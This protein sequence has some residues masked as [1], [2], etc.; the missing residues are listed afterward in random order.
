MERD[1]PATVSSGWP[2]SHMQGHLQQLRKVSWNI[3]LS[4]SHPPV[5]KTHVVHEEVGKGKINKLYPRPL[6]YSVKVKSGEQCFLS[7]QARSEAVSRERNSVYSRMGKRAGDRVL[8]R[9]FVSACVTAMKSHFIPQQW[10]VY[11]VNSYMQPGT[12]QK[13][14]Q[15]RGGKSRCNPCSHT[16][17]VCSHAHDHHQA[18]VFPA[19]CSQNSCS[20]S[21]AASEGC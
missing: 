20:S 8:G 18:T 6:S 16:V 5:I 21:P 15:D 11:F 10:S 1:T 9:V 19:L 17:T 2:E 12:L 7:P 14:N 13:G 4:S 3:S